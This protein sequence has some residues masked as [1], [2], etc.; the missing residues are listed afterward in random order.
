MMSRLESRMDTSEVIMQ[1]LA[2]FAKKALEELQ[3]LSDDSGANL[4]SIERETDTEQ[5]G[6]EPELLYDG[7]KGQ[8]NL[9][10]LGGSI[11]ADKNWLLATN[12]WTLDELRTQFVDS[13][14][15]AKENSRVRGPTDPDKTEII[16]EATRQ[17]LGQRFTEKLY[18]RILYLVNQRGRDIKKKLDV[19]GINKTPEQISL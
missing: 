10:A 6:E 19:P 1:D 15:T 18:K 4:R 5:K 11:D 14:R 17:V 13:E 8:V 12:I 16:K 2:K 9:L 3:R 7:V